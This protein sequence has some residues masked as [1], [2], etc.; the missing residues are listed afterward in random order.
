MTKIGRAFSLSCDITVLI[1]AMIYMYISYNRERIIHD[2]NKTKTYVASMCVKL[3]YI[4]HTYETPT[5]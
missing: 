3:Q 5:Y 1:Q 4:I 2:V